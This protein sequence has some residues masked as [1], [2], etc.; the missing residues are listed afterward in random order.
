[1]SNEVIAP[2]R[3]SVLS[4]APAWCYLSDVLNFLV[5]EERFHDAFRIARQFPNRGVEASLDKS[6]KDYGFT[7]TGYD[8]IDFQE[9][10]DF[11]PGNTE[12]QVRLRSHVTRYAY[13]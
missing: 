3:V 2:V 9:I 10:L 12:F 1:M 5:Q 6:R 8:R 7:V 4:K 11:F 13:N